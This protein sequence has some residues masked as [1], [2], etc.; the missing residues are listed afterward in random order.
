VFAG[1][2][3]SMAWPVANTDLKRVEK[4]E[5]PDRTAWAH[6]LAYAQW[7]AWELRE[8]VAWARLRPHAKKPPAKRGEL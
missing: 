2:R 7:N 1:S 8:G 6:A 5:L 4:P 3:A